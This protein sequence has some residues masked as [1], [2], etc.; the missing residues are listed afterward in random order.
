MIALTRAEAE[1]RAAAVDVAGY[2]IE[3]DLT[4]DG[5][6]FT[7]TTTITFTAH[8]PQT[9]VEVV[10][11]ELIEATLDGQPLAA[12]PY[13]DGRLALTGL[14]GTHELVVRARMDYSHDGEGLHKFT[15]PADGNVY[16]C[17]TSSVDNAKRWFACFDQPDLKA[18]F[19]LRVRCPEEWTVVGNGAATRTGPGVWQLAETAPIATYLVTLV[20]GRY[21]SVLGEHDGIPLGLHVRAALADDLDRDAPDLL[22]LTGRSL[23]AFHD[24]F[25]VRYPFGEYHQA[26]V[27]EFNWGAM[28][29][30]G[31]VTFRDQMIFHS[32][33]T[34]GE[35]VQR[36]TTVVHEM[37]HMW[38]GDLVTMR[39][40]DDLWLNESFAEYLA[41]RVTTLI[42]DMPA[43]ADFSAA[44]KG[45]GYAADRRASTHPVAGNGAADA[46]S[47]LED[48]DG[49]SYAKGA[50]VLR[51]LSA[52]LGDDMF[53]AGLRE[54]VRTN[55][56]GN[57]TFADLLSAWASQAG[58]GTPTGDDLERWAHNWL[59]SAGVDIVSVTASDDAHGFD[60]RRAAPLFGPPA[61]RP[62]ALSVRVLPDGSTRDVLLETDQLALE[63]ADVAAHQIVV[64]NAGDESWATVRLVDAQWALV[65]DVLAQTRDDTVRVVLW[66]A[67]RTALADGL[68]APDLAVRAVIAGMPYESDVV[69]GRVLRWVTDALPRFVAPGVKRDELTTSLAAA[70]RTGLEVAPAASSA[71]LT[72]ARA[73]IAL[74]AD[75]EQLRGWTA[76]ARPVDGLH[77]DDELRWLAL[78]R[79]AA[80]GDLSDEQIDAAYDADHSASALVH[81]TRCRALRPD[82]AAK[83]QAWDALIDPDT[84]L[85]QYQ[86]IAL[87]D[88]IS[89]P[90]QEKL[91]QPYAQRWFTDMP[92]TARFRSGWALTGIA[93]PSFPSLAV[94][95]DTLT[96]AEEFVARSDQPSALRR[97]A[98]DE[99]DEMRRAIA[100]RGLL[101]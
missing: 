12:D 64:P 87:A 76:D 7:S 13:A 20:A 100:V 26:F 85:S 2:R 68:V 42:S 62:H 71:Q 35:L 58:A 36:A 14:G 41:H 98:S 44:R 59:R 34:E 67:L 38:F 99:A 66:N 31:C 53:L 75:A 79:R 45:W 3:L 91:A 37:A 18:R 94:E 52:Y 21:H 80:L 9:F 51:Q 86:L 6:Q 101:G 11:T 5:D 69:I 65:P 81:A 63:L 84:A 24:L 25:E 48:F 29:N 73:W 23:D 88:G 40:W 27:P 50:S 30:P 49:I 19:E 55:A 39:W 57:A 8:E 17:A 56:Y 32:K 70:V 83:A 78:E 90:G 28:E 47:A 77:V 97:I 15:D 82:A 96:A 60:L 16:L 22:E 33:P 1:Q 61:D 93:G 4:G 72:A 10:C 43:W 54:H 89:V 92:A 74:T 46:R 95:Q